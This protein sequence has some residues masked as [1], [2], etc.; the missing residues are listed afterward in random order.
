MRVGKRE[1]FGKAAVL[2]EE[3]L[4]GRALRRFDGAFGEGD[5]PGRKGGDSLG[6]LV[7]KGPELLRGQ[8]TVDPAI[9]LGRLGVVVTTAENGLDAITMTSNRKFD[10]LIIDLS[11]PIM[12][13]KEAYYKIREFDKDLPVIMASGYSSDR[14]ASIEDDLLVYLQ[15]PFIYDNLRKSII[16][17]LN[18]RKGDKI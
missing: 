3:T 4:G 8:R 9:T 15:K 11:M 1:G 18:Q 7:D 14:V 16:T 17:L 6:Q 2:F 13:G 5:G 12:G 10:L